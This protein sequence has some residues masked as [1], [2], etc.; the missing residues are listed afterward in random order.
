MIYEKWITEFGEKQVTLLLKF[1]NS[2]VW[3]HNE[4]YWIFDFGVLHERITPY[5]FLEYR[6]N[7]PMPDTLTLE[8]EKLS[9]LE[10]QVVKCIESKHL[11]NFTLRVEHLSNDSEQKEDS[12]KNAN[13]SEEDSSEDASWIDGN[14]IQE[15]LE[16]SFAKRAY[17]ELYKKNVQILEKC[18]PCDSIF[19]HVSMHDAW[20]IQQCFETLSVYGFVASIRLFLAFHILLEEMGTILNLSV[21]MMLYSMPAIVHPFSSPVQPQSL[22]VCEQIAIPFIDR[23]F[24]WYARGLVDNEL[25]F[26]CH[27]NHYEFLGKFYETDFVCR[28]IS[29]RK[30]HHVLN[31]DDFAKIV[32]NR[33]AHSK[34]LLMVI[35]PS[36]NTVLIGD[37]ESDV[38]N[39]EKEEEE[40]QDETKK[41][42]G[43]RECFP[44]WCAENATTK[45]LPLEE[46]MRHILEFRDSF[47]VKISISENEKKNSK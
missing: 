22:Y 20:K 6:K 15:F 26:L 10:K 47:K 24:N 41:A 5:C 43:V 30:N 39:E 19:K 27:S 32:R 3:K 25:W 16:N 38:K 44:K 42:I 12:M 17:K 35:Q 14:M 9:W 23:M 18:N 29:P 28:R 40:S 33:S 31:W 46:D 21:D 2:Y 36:K 7:D 1:E 4:R 37:E 8:S 34:Y 11:F 13:Q 45:D